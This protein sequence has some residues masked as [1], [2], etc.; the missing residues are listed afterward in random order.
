VEVADTGIGI[1]VSQ[2]RLIF[3]DFAQAEGSSTR[4]YG[5]T[6]LGLSISKKLVELLGGNIGMDSTPG[7]GSRFWFDI[8]VDLVEGRRQAL[9]PSR[10]FRSDE[11]DNRKAYEDDQARN[12]VRPQYNAKILVA[13]DNRINQLVVGDLLRTFGLEAIIVDDGE[14]AVE[15]ATEQ[16]VDL[17]IMDIQMPGMDG[18]EAAARIRL[19]ESNRG[20]EHVPIIAFTA[21]AMAGDREKSLNDGMDDYISKPVELES[22]SRLLDHWLGHRQVW[23]KASTAGI[24]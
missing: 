4:R 7:E 18:F 17:I 6:G 9:P 23:G 21:H 24:R 15:V 13:E 16:E 1:P 12:L 2:H 8:P 14:A 19:M 3:N 5:G 10:T 20:T 22:F 11:F